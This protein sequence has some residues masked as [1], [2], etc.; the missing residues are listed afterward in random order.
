M[1]TKQVGEI[2]GIRQQ[3]Y[4]RYE[5]NPMDMPSDYIVK[6]AILYNVS[7]DYLL[8]LSNSPHL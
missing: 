1:S 7:S 3:T 5:N 2:L 4:I 6:L 8:G